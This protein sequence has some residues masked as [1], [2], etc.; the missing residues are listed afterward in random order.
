MRGGVG[1]VK[2]GCTCG[3]AILPAEKAIQKGYDPVFWLSDARTLYVSEWG[4]IN[5]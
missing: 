5:L 3:T 1:T 2:T 4:F